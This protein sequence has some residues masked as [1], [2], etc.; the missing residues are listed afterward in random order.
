MESEAEINKKYPAVKLITG[1]LFW[2]IEGKFTCKKGSA[3]QIY[4]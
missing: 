4:Y 2:I 3:A 1:S